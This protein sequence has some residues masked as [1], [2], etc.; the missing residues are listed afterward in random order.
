MIYFDQPTRKA[1]VHR[2]CQQL[3]PGGWLFIGHSES[4]G[5]DNSVNFSYVQPA[6]YQKA[7]VAVMLGKVRVLV[8]DDSR[9]IRESLRS[10]DA[11]SRH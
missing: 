4:L 7:A 1:L 8:V 2:L 11:K 6:V 10:L 9:F 3:V 5:R